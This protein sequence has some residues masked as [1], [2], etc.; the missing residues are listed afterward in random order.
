MSMIH[1]GDFK[2]GI[3]IKTKESLLVKL[4]YCGFRT[5]QSR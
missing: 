5:D 3:G 1:K 2:Y 4:F